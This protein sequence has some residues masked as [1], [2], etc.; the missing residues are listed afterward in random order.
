MSCKPCSQTSVVTDASGPLIQLYQNSKF[1]PSLTMLLNALDQVEVRMRSESVNV[2]WKPSNFPEKMVPYN[3]KPQGT[4][5]ISRPTPLF[6]EENDPYVYDLYTPSPEGG[7]VEGQSLCA[8]PPANRVPGDTYQS[9]TWRMQG[10]AW[11]TPT[12]C[13]KDLLFYENGPEVLRRFLMNVEKTPAYFY[14]NFIRNLIWDTGEKYILGATTMGLLWNAPNRVSARVAPNLADY[15]TVSSNADADAAAPKVVALTY[16]RYILD[17][18]MGEDITPLNVEGQRELMMVGVE[19]DIHG[20]VYN[21]SDVTPSAHVQGG[22]GFNPMSFSIVGSLPYGVKFDK[23]WFRGDFDADGEFQR[24]PAKVYV[25][26]NGG[27]DLRTNPA[28]LNAPY[29]VLTFMTSRPFNYRRFSSLP[30]F[31]SNVP[32]E[33][34]RFLSPRFQFA[35][36]MEKCSYTRGLVSWRAED[37]FGFQPTGE[38]IIHVIYRRDE[39]SSYLREA[40]VGT[41]AEEITSVNVP[42]PTTCASAGV[43][44][45]NPAPG[46]ILDS[47][48]YTDTAYT[49]SY[50]PGLAAEL[51]WTLPDDLP[52]DAQ[53]QTAKGV[54]DVKVVAVNSDATLITFYVD[55]DQHNGGHFCAEDQLIGFVTSSPTAGCQAL[56]DGGLKPDPFVNT[57]LLGNLGSALNAVATDVVTVFFDNGC[58]TARLVEFTIASIDNTTGRIALTATAAD[59][60][61][62]INCED[63]VKVCANNTE[64]CDGCLPTEASCSETAGLTPI[65]LD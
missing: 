65:P 23:M 46:G 36:L 34:L 20:F 8:E 50:S 30:S 22:A 12:F 33:S 56:L 47:I 59:W 28:W 31:P 18:F 27:R 48:D 6:F 10:T 63:A 42:I 51:G 17:Q 19:P 49:V 41:L 21:D 39:L 40:K 11:E 44:G 16:L 13:L 60:L 4:E 25:D 32:E 2:S 54:F 29:G 37:E 55:P 9:F 15:K 3:Q 1:S 62:G 43:L 14:D 38:K 61:D 58:G 24:I 64:G 57:T 7:I 26:Q 5:V 53:F 45:C 35:P 52:I